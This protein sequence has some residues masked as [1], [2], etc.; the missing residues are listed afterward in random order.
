MIYFDW[1]RGREDLLAEMRLSLSDIFESTDYTIVRNPTD[2]E[3]MNNIYIRGNSKRVAFVIP[4]KKRQTFTFAFKTDYLA[5]IQS[6]G[7]KLGELKEIKP[8]RCPYWRKYEN[9]TFDDLRCALS[10]FVKH[11]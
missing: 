6:S 7:A 5:V 3:M 11:K 4:V 8:G 2:N 1:D 10:A 9:L